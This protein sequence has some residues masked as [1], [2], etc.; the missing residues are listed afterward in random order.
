M[1]RA[2]VVWSWGSTDSG[3]ATGWL[4]RS[5]DRQLGRG[6]SGERRLSSSC[7]PAA[8]AG[9]ARSRLDEQPQRCVESHAVPASMLVVGVGA[10]GSSAIFSA[11]GSR[12]VLFQAAA[13][14]RRRTQTYP[15]NRSSFG[16][17][18]RGREASGRSNRSSGAERVR[19][20]SQ[21]ARD[22]AKRSR[23]GR[24]WWVQALPA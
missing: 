17:R 22:S 18:H 21:R 1:S 19:W 2:E 8:R 3:A 20:S 16:V 4:A 6:G 5:C 23:R 14:R 24:G 7:A 9:V 15:R 12:V 10:G 13:I 11:F